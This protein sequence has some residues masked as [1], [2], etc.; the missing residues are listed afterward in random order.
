MQRAKPNLAAG[1]QAT[2]AI[3]PT[4]LMWGIGLLMSSMWVLP[5]LD[6]SGKWLLGHGVSVIFLSWVR[7]AMHLLIMLAAIVPG[8]GI[9]VLKSQRPRDQM[10]R[11]ASMLTS[12][13][14]FFT[15]LHYLP[16]A[17]A[18]SISFLAP[19]LLLLIAPLVLKEPARI[20]RWAAAGCAFVGVLIIIRPGSGLD[21]VGVT[22]GLLGAFCFT[23]QYIFTRRVAG[24][25]P[26]TT[27]IWS[28]AV[29]TALLTPVLFLVPAADWAV[30]SNMGPGAWF[31]LCSTGL[32]GALG[33]LLQIGAYRNAPASA[34]AP[35]TYFSVI[36]ASIVGWIVSGHFPD[37]VTWIGIGVIF[38]SGVGTGIYEWRGPRR[39]AA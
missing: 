1:G 16:Q 6:A 17:E 13:L 37:K 36:S 14:M 2:T 18:T 33:H 23:S 11:G 4:R 20:S 27:I 19:L 32:T 38:L 10:L 5:L 31:L 26:Y 3:P 39:T 25:D 21:P 34:L 15:S 30:L 24:D 28:G 9:K 29:G 8:R 35:F 22:I 12:T 7:Y